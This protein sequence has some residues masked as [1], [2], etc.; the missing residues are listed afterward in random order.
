MFQTVVIRRRLNKILLLAQV[1]QRGVDHNPAYPPAQRAFTP[2]LR[3]VAVNPDKAL[4]QHIFRLRPIARK[5]Q[6]HPEHGH[7]VLLVE[8]F[9]VRRAALEHAAN[10]I[11]IAVLLHEFGIQMIDDKQGG[12]VARCVNFF[13]NYLAGS[14]SSF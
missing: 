11:L 14:P 5:A 7:A 13:C 9:L 3:H 6:Q 12:G 2:E 8:R 1:A 4:L 10:Q